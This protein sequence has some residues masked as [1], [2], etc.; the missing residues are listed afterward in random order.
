MSRR[1]PTHFI[2][3]IVVVAV[4]VLLLL[5]SLDVLD[6]GDLFQWI[7][8]LFILFGLWLLVKNRFRRIAG[9]LIMILIAVFVQFLVLGL[10][11]G[12]FWP[13]I[14]VAIGI[15]IL[16]KSFRPGPRRA[17]VTSM[18]DNDGW[19]ESVSVMGS[20]NERV[21]S[22]EFKGGQA[23]A[24]MG[25]NT[26]DLRESSVAEKPATLEATVVM[27]EM[28]L[29]IPEEWNVQVDNVTV[30]GESKDERTRRDP[31]D[32]HP[33][34]VVSGTVVMGSLKIED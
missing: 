10:D 13:L 11:M 7:P 20:A 8:S 34:L 15:T 16:I 22:D 9:P 32:G 5:G 19:I 33:D 17:G 4:G 2:I 3:G 24:V 25:E 27:G 18:D 29:R 28:K 31:E 1:T 23:T 26:L 14:L 21:A 6:I 12:K 30:M